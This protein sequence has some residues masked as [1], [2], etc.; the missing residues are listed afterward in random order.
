MAEYAIN[1]TE[2]DVLDA[3]TYVPIG[4]KEQ[5]TRAIAFLCLEP[6]EVRTD[7]DSEDYLPLMFRENKKLKAQ[8]LM[9]VLAML[10][11]KP[12]TSQK[13]ASGEELTGCMDEPEYDAWASSH[14]MNQLERMKKGKN[15]PVVNSLF[16]L[17]YE[18]KAFE[19]MLTGAI[20]DELEERND[21][22]NRTMQWF[23][24]S[25]ADAGVRELIGTV[26]REA[27]ENGKVDADG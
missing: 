8:Y 3:E 7:E 12:F 5:F 4:T 6:V 22:F 26:I 17:L 25:A 19:F 24:L 23:G 18:Y 9:G 1:I 2:Q 16:D 13:L 15:G 20:R 10:L 11:K 21:V 14:V 27:A